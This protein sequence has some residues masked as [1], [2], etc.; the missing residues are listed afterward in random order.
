MYKA[1]EY[2]A[3]TGSN[4]QR[5]FHPPLA[6]PNIHTHL[7]ISLECVRLLCCTKLLHLC[8]SCWCFAMCFHSVIRNIF[9]SVKH[10]NNAS[11][12]SF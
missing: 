9:Q 2:P 4:R 3:G 5:E 7:L 8:L 1:C 10:L 6:H 11:R 12:E